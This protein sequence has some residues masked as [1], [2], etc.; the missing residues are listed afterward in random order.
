MIHL[1]DN[2]YPQWFLI[3]NYSVQGCFDIQFIDG[4]YPY[5]PNSIYLV[6]CAYSQLL[7][8]KMESVFGFF[9]SSATIQYA[10]SSDG[11]FLKW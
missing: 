9:F 5:F 3:R 10:R 11:K 1:V 4:L 2:F 8:S 7:F 6:L